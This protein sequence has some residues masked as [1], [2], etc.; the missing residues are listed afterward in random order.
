MA[1]AHVLHHA[2]PFYAAFRGS[3]SSLLSWESL[4]AFWDTVRASPE[5]WHIY[6]IGE[7][8]P[9]APCSAEET[10]RFVDA[11]D[12][13]LREDHHEDYCGIVYADNKDHPTLIK[14][15]DPH[16]LGVA[17]GFS[18]NPPLPGWVMSHLPPCHLEDRRPLPESRRRWWRAV[19]A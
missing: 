18:D 15:F 7:H 11:I 8:A 16:N 6:A 4:D 17:C 2:N 19:W 14:I 5:G 1:K 3:F 12:K 9:D 10:L 13:L